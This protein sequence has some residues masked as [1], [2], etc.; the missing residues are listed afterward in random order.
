M[1][2]GL[3]SS[4]QVGFGG[5]GDQNKCINAL[6]SHKVEIKAGFE[7]LQNSFQAK[8]SDEID[9]IAMNIISLFEKEMPKGKG[10]QS[11]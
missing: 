11:L 1:G 5:R 10:T 4:G 2:F 9:L 7:D 6:K 3:D 8:V